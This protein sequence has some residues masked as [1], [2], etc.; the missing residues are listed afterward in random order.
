MLA[1]AWSISDARAASD[2]EALI[3][4][5]AYADA[6]DAASAVMS[7]GSQLLAAEA[8]LD[9]VVYGPAATESS[10]AQ[11]RWLRRGVDAAQNAVKLDPDSAAALV[12]LA[13][14]KGEIARRSGVLQN[15][16]V[17]GELKQLFDQAL[18]LDP[19]DADALVGLALWNLELVKAGVGWLYGANKN[20]VL[21]LLE[22]GVAAAPEQVNLRVEYG[23]ALRELGDDAAAKQQLELALRLPAT[24][25]ADQVEL[26]RAK[27]LLNADD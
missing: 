21:P 13:R 25:F 16:N 2:P 26:E 1:I 22:R 17:A 4:K 14:G 12:Q 6:Y 27:A 15:L 19:D 8:A 23:N 5:G 3:Q 18:A 20:A 10:E 9:Q 11:L 7:G 24:S